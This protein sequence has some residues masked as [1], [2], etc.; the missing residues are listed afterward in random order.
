M[1][2]GPKTRRKSRLQRQ[3][4]QGPRQNG[5][6]NAAKRG[7]SEEVPYWAHMGSFLTAKKV[8]HRKRKPSK[9]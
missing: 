9:K 8:T 6:S 7:L 1:P 5:R 2:V 3:P 4:A